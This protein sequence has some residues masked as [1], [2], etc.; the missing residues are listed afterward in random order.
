MLEPRD[1]QLYFLPRIIWKQF[2]QT[3]CVPRYPQL[4]LH[5]FLKNKSRTKKSRTLGLH[6]GARTLPNKAA[7]SLKDISATSNSFSK[8]IESR[9]VTLDYSL[10]IMLDNL[11]FRELKAFLLVY[12]TNHHERNVLLLPK[13]VVGDFLFKLCSTSQ[14]FLCWCSK[15]I[16]NC[17][18]NH[19]FICKF[20][21]LNTYSSY[22]LI[23]ACWNLDM[24]NKLCCT[25]GW[26]YSYHSVRNSIIQVSN[27]LIPPGLKKES[28]IHSKWQLSS[29]LKA[30]FH[31]VTMK[32]VSVTLHVL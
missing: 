27:S 13:N 7:I 20:I 9:L 30:S 14:P 24:C 22:V 10:L 1:L 25:M 29:I 32:I 12:P 26:L 8:F 5:K 3:T 31:N 23:L 11:I 21:C 18:S 16:S 6:F 17:K 2:N 28:P 4:Q 19:R 15:V